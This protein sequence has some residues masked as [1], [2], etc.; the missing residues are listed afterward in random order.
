MKMA[1]PR[2]SLIISAVSTPAGLTSPIT[3]FAPKRANRSDAALPIPLLPPVTSA[4]FPEKLNADVFMRVSRALETSYYDARL[5]FGN[6]GESEDN[7]LESFH[8][9]HRRRRPS[10]VESN[11]LCPISAEEK[12]KVFV[13]GSWQPVRALCRIGW[14]TRLDVDLCAGHRSRRRLPASSSKSD[15]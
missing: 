5:R 15:S 14:L 10:T 4:T 13:L 3:T 8:F 2:S 12:R 1:S 11:R 6:A 9:L 7:N